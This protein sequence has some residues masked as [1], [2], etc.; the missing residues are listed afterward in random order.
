M[1]E[2]SVDLL[3]HL[4]IVIFFSVCST[5]LV[6]FMSEPVVLTAR[7]WADYSSEQLIVGFR[8]N[9][10]IKQVEALLVEHRK[11]ELLRKYCS[12]EAMNAE[13]ETRRLLGAD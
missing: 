9:S 13:H 4:V 12:D 6:F 10:D 1:T 11:Q 5:I 8:F 7:I 2:N 3:M